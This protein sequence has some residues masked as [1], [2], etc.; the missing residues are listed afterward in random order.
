[1]WEAVRRRLDDLANHPEGKAE[2]ECAPT[3]K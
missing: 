2:D 1:L 3:P